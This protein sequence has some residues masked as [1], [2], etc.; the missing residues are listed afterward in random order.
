MANTRRTQSTSG[1]LL[2]L[3]SVILVLYFAREVLVPLAL[4][5]LRGLSL[6]QAGLVLSVG[7]LSWSFGFEAPPRAEEV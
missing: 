2:I 5:E 7:A 6:T 3:A 4:G 1:S